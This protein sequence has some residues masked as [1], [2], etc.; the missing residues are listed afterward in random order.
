MVTIELVG[1]NR[2]DGLRIVVPDPPPLYY[3][4]A[5]Q[6]QAAYRRLISFRPEDQAFDPER[7][8][9]VVQLIFDRDHVTP[10]GI[11][12]YRFNPGATLG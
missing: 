7:S 3:K 8:L 12:I 4:V 6:D 1:F 11:W 9:D 5:A 10:E 2:L